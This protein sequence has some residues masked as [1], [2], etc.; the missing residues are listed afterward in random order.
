MVTGGP[1]LGD[2][3]RTCGAPEGRARDTEP[4][5]LAWVR[6]SGPAAARNPRRSAPPAAA[7]RGSPAPP[8]A[9]RGQQAPRPARPSPPPPH[10]PLTG[11]T[12]PGAGAG[13]G[14]AAGAGV[15]ALGSPSAWAPSAAGAARAAGGGQPTGP[16]TPR[17]APV[18]QPGKAAIGR[19][20]RAPLCPTPVGREARPSEASAGRGF[21][22]LR[23]G[24]FPP[25]WASWAVA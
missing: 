3:Q 16:R 21:R 20:R 2:T 10:S 13:A 9:L 6:Q 1:P 11:T 24:R 5:G 22:E 18:R 23:G 15:G 14:A 12:A 7:A 25:G 17:P 19:A 4:K 8:R